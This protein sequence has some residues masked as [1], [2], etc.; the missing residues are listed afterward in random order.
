MPPTDEQIEHFYR[1]GYLLLPGLVSPSRA[2]AV[3]EAAPGDLQTDGRWRALVFNHDDPRQDA[4]VHQLLVEP[5]VVEAVEAL[6][7]GPARVW[8]GMFAV[9]PASGGHGL[10]W[11]QDNQYTRLLGPALNVFIALCPISEE[12]AGLWVAPRSHPAGGRRAGRNDTAAPGHRE[13]LEDPENGMPLPPM[14]PGDACIFDR[15]M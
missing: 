1:E 13:A 9:V 14:Q 2:R 10:P 15:H 12:N 3:L 8:Y 7:A 11:H 5:A 6:F 4:P